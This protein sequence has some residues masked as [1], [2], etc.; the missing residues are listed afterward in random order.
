M[1]GVCLVAWHE[2]CWPLRRL[3]NFYSGLA[4]STARKQGF[5]SLPSNI[6]PS[7]GELLPSMDTPASLSVLKSRAAF[8]PPPPPHSGARAVLGQSAERVFDLLFRQIAEGDSQTIGEADDPSPERSHP[9]RKSKTLAADPTFQALLSSVPVV[10]LAPSSA[11]GWVTP[12]LSPGLRAELPSV[13][14]PALRRK[15]ALKLVGREV[16]LLSEPDF[17]GIKGNDVHSP[18][19]DELL[20]QNAGLNFSSESQKMLGAIELMA[21]GAQQF[22][23]DLQ[24][25]T[26]A[27]SAC[28]RL[29]RP[30]AAVALFRAM[31]EILAVVPTAEDYTALAFAF[32]FNREM[33]KACDVVQL[34]KANGVEPPVAIWNVLMRGF[35]AMRAYQHAWELYYGMK[36][37][38][39]CQ[40]TEETYTVMLLACARQ[41]MVFRAE[42]LLYEM[43]HVAGLVPLPQTFRAML[44]AYVHSPVEPKHL[45]AEEVLVQMEGYGF[46]PTLRDY[47]LYF[48][49]LARSGD[50]PALKRGVARMRQR[51]LTPDEKTVIELIRCCG[52]VLPALAHPHPH[53]PFS[54]PSHPRPLRQTWHP[55]SL[56]LSL[57]LFQN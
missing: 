4:E 29:Q 20:T 1:K 53:H 19:A 13:D 51:G 3:Q 16:P 42:T 23:G 17:E 28:G 14:S 27:L 41:G 37:F 52:S 40:P 44:L 5:P 7:P 50:Y 21:A 46:R 55:K 12:L 54:P 18:C 56:S 31:Q 49:A 33:D 38:T 26:A 15:T 8:A 48:R 35:V 39:D 34:M 32:A 57:P 24:T 10:R 6:L 22:G 11:G 9:Q 25:Y 45:E 2:I 47:N 43:T 36:R 30:D